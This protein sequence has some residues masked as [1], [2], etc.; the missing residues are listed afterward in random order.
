MAKYWQKRPEYAAVQLLPENKEE[1]INLTRGDVAF[2]DR[3]VYL[4]IKHEVRTET[5]GLW[6]VFYPNGAIVS[7][8]NEQFNQEFEP[9]S[10]EPSPMVVAVT[11]DPV[12]ELCE[13]LRLTIEYAGNK[14]LPPIEGWIWYDALVKY[15]PETASIF[16]AS[17]EAKSNA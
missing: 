11:I 2:S 10:I 13:V 17:Y 14:I 7:Y 12:K 5:V 1:I 4:T 6:L 16:K 15:A 8:A 3:A 9:T